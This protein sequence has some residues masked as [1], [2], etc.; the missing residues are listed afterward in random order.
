M[1]RLILFDIDGTLIW[2]GPA[3]DAFHVALVDA[4]GVTGP[5][6]VHEFSGKT[7]PQIARELLT[8]VGL[9]DA[10]VDAGF[11]TLWQRYQEELEQ[12]LPER[13]V[14]VLAGVEDLL[15]A[16]GDSGRAGLGLVTGNIL[17][18]ARLKLC[19]AGLFERFEVGSYGSDDEVRDHLPAIA[20]ERARRHFGAPFPESE[21]VIVGDTPR[22]VACGRHAGCR[23]VAVATGSFS[24][25]ALCRTEADHVLPDLSD[26]EAVLRALLN[27]VSPP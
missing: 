21:V 3:K 17:G 16:L 1:K 18:G 27:G 7:D 8:G 10:E 12:R 15:D 26:T 5:I 9:T 4:F 23:T 6:E 13:P 19:S 22:D 14:R 2:G 24:V 11:P 20:I 25:E